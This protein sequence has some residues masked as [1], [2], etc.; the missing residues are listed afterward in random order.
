[1]SKRCGERSAPEGGGE[2]IGLWRAGP[3]V[4]AHLS[5][6]MRTAGFPSMHGFT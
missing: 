4:G 5:K 3:P 1:M 2:A 6:V